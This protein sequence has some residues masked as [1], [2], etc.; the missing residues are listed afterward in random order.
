MRIGVSLAETTAALTTSAAEKRNNVC[1]IFMAARGV[2]PSGSLPLQLEY[3][4]TIRRDRNLPL[5]DCY[6]HRRFIGGLWYG[7]INESL[8][9]VHLI[10]DNLHFVSKLKF[11]FVLAADERRARRI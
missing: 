3:S 8:L 4:I 9:T 1:P 7:E 11:S 10:H 5:Y 6:H 2:I